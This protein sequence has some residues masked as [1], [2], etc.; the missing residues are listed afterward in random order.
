LVESLEKQRVTA[1]TEVRQRGAA[2]KFFAVRPQVLRRI[3]TAPRLTVLK[4]SKA[5]SVR[6]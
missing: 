3:F 6:C 2:K 5:F 4:P 1:L